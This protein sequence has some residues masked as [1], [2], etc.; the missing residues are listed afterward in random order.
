MVGLTFVLCS[1]KGEENTCSTAWELTPPM[2]EAS[3][4]LKGCGACLCYHK[5]YPQ[6]YL[7]HYEERKAYF[8]AGDTL[9]S[10]ELAL[11]NVPVGYGS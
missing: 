5:V 11:L 4:L 2:T 1:N 10:K 7:F 6:N 8:L 3:V 9:C